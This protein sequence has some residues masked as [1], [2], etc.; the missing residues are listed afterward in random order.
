MSLMSR[1]LDQFWLV[2]LS[3]WEEQSQDAIAA[4]GLDA[5]RV[6]LHR[7]CHG[8]VEATG[9]SLATVQ[10]GLLGI[11]HRLG[12]GQANRVALHLN[13][14]VRLLDPR[15]LGYEDE[16]VALTEYIHGRIAAAAAWAGCEPTARPE[17][18][19]GLL[20]ARKRIESICEQCHC[21]LPPCCS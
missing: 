18:V 12:A 16:V 10:G 19:Q 2:A 3:A 4:F 20:Q 21:P 6:D 5:I 15:D 7:Q 8:S 13:R 1:Y 9:Q 17:R 14:Q 11:A